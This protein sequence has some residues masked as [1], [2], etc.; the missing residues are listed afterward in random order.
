MVCLE[1]KH[2]V[3]GCARWRAGFDN[4]E[5]VSLHRV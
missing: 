1:V 5:A 4:H 2:T 3:A